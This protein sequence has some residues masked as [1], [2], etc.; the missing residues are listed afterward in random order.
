MQTKEV[1]LREQRR[2]RTWN[3]LHQ[4]AVQLVKAQGVKGT[5]TDAIASAAGVSPRT[6]FNYFAT[7]EDAI[8]GLRQPM[9]TDAILAQD[10]Q[11]QDLYIF[12]RITHMSLDILRGSTKPDALPFIREMMH[13]Y[14]ELRMRL[15]WWQLS[16]E[17]VLQ[18]YLST[19]DW[20]K[21]SQ[22]GRL[23][24]FPL[25][26]DGAELPEGADERVRAAV[27]ITSAALRHLQFHRVDFDPDTINER[28]AESIAIFRM[29]LRAD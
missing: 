6:F 25:R 27:L 11:R 13:T 22:N 1:S 4:A 19:V 26:D 24:P 29:L 9:M 21:F 23:G 5:T 15:K 2:D 7:K 17:Q 18:D 3:A 8:L 28:I 14:P 20:E 16:A 12:E 10:A